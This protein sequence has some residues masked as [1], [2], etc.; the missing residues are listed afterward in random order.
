MFFV[1]GISDG[2]LAPFI[3]KHAS[4]TTVSSFGANPGQNILIPPCKRI[5]DP[6][7]IVVHEPLDDGLVEGVVI[8]EIVL[9]TPRSL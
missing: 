7:V 5:V 9:G 8:E 4:T 1:E 6:R 2:Y 3:P